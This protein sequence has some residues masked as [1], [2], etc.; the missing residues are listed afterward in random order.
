MG[1]RWAQ[2]FKKFSLGQYAICKGLL[3]QNCIYIQKVDTILSF[4]GTYHLFLQEY[5]DEINHMLHFQ[6]ECTSIKNEA[7]T[8]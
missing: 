5:R 8:F 6:L 7:I 1:Q 4:K 3:F 2:P